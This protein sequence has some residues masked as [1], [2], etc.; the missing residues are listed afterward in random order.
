MQ[1]TNI[2]GEKLIP[3]STAPMTGFFRDGCCNTNE[4]DHGLHTVCII[5]TDKFL[6]FSAAMGND[7]STPYPAYGFS[8]LK[9]G[10]Q[11]C[12]CATRFLEAH[13]NNAAPMVVL[14][15]T[16]EATLEIVSMDVLISYAFKSV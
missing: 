7:L 4:E 1:T 3:C 13:Q 2:F 14:E 8:G 15:A 9:A 16:N 6:K 12:L 11:W 5:C 10:D